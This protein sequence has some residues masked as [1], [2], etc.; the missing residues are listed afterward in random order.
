MPL[1]RHPRGTPRYAPI[2]GADEAALA[3]ASCRHGY[4]DL[5]AL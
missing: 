5:T 1:V 4:R 2:Q 3:A